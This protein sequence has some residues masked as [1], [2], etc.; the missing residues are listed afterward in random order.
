MTARRLHP[1]SLWGALF[2]VASQFVRFWIGG[3]V[4][5]QAVARAILG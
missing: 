4:L 5:W 3:S 1:A 2:V